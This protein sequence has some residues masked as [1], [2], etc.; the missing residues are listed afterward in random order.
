[1]RRSPRSLVAGSVASG[2]EGEGGAISHEGRNQR[3]RGVGG[4]RSNA[5]STAAVIS[6]LEPSVAS[7]PR[8]PAITSTLSRST[9]AVAPA[10]IGRMM[11]GCRVD[12]V[13]AQAVGWVGARGRPCRPRPAAGLRDGAPSDN[14]RTPRV[15]GQ[16]RVAQNHVVGLHAPEDEHGAGPEA[17]DRKVGARGP[18]RPGHGHVRPGRCTGAG[19]RAGE[20]ASGE[21]SGAAWI[22]ED[23]VGWRSLVGTY[24]RRWSGIC[25]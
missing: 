8:P 15:R 7:V 14:P 23:T 3:G 19:G 10:R 25:R 21:L 17:S 24:C 6:V 1:M 16:P 12:Q 13:P 5:P 22:G 4:L 11:V 9:V 18:Q 2:G 20:C